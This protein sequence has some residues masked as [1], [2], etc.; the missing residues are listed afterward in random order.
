MDT[1]IGLIK[2]G[3]EQFVEC[4]VYHKGAKM[5]DGN[6][7]SIVVGNVKMICHIHNR[8]LYHTCM[9]YNVVVKHFWVIRVWFNMIYF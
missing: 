1:V 6:V 4:Q 3:M 7:R 2:I 8:T 5:A 9:L